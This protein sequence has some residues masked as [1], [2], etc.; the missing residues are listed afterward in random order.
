MGN[1]SGIKTKSVNGLTL[2]EL[3]SEKARCEDL[4][5][6]CPNKIKKAIV[7]RLDLIKERLK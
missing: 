1:R 2:N 6:V 7:K 5:L 3:R 4:L